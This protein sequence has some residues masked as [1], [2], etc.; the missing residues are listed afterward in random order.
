MSVRSRSNWNLE[1]LVFK[2]RGKPEYLE[3][4]PSEQ[5]RAPTT[6]STHIWLQHQDLN[7]GHT[8][9]R[10]VLSPLRHPCYPSQ[11]ED[12]MHLKYSSPF[13][14]MFWIHVWATNFGSARLSL[15]TRA[16]GFPPALMSI[17]PGYF[18]KKQEENRFKRISSISHDKLLADNRP[19]LFTM[20]VCPTR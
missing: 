9:G 8:G 4:N 12:F 3:K 15:M 10:W 2:D 6:N 5:M 11:L 13:W 18:Y 14:E 20:D 17:T 19:S 7:P 16:W 1:M